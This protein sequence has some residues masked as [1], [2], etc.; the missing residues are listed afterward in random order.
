MTRRLG[1][2]GDSSRPAVRGDS[3]V[4][5]MIAMVLFLFIFIAVLQTSL[6][7]MDADTRN[8]LRNEAIRIAAQSMNEARSKPFANLANTAGT[9]TINR[10]FR[11][12]T[13]PFTVINSPV[14]ISQ[15]DEQMTVQVKWN[16][17]GQPY[18]HTIQTVINN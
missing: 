8:M 18:T 3:L 6:L 15:D 12:M 7:A 1:L 9:Y 11:S 16:W 17:R 2:R 13:I 10:S 14:A 4:E 5:V